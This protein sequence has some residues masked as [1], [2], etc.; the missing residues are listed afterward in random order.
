MAER[1][2]SSRAS[3]TNEAQGV[4]QVLGPGIRGLHGHRRGGARTGVEP[5][6]PGS[7]VSQPDAVQRGRN[8]G[9]TWQLARRCDHMLAKATGRHSQRPP[10]LRCQLLHRDRWRSPWRWAV[11]G[12][13]LAELA[14]WVQRVA[15]SA[16]WWRVKAAVYTFMSHSNLGAWNHVESLDVVRSAADDGRLSSDLPVWHWRCNDSPHSAQHQ[17][18]QL[19]RWPKQ[20]RWP[21]PWWRSTAERADAHGGRGPAPK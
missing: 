16:H 6:V 4:P 10:D 1:K 21:V 8:H 11:A 3:P 20:S 5:G 12:L 17:Q 9:S 7:R 14:A 19:A 18:V 15:K 13:A 2:G